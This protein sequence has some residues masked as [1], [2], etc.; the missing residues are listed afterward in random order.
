MKII[1]LVTL[2]IVI[3]IVVLSQES[4]IQKDDF[5][6]LSNTVIIKIKD[7]SLRTFE[8]EQKIN[9]AFKRKVVQEIKPIFNEFTNSLKKGEESLSRIL[10]LKIGSGTDPFL[11]AKKISRLK[12]IEWAEPK[13]I[14]KVT[15]E[16]NDSM[17]LINQQQNLFR[18]LASK[19]WDITKGDSSVIIGIVDTGVDWNHPDISANIYRDNDGNIVGYD[20]GGLNGTPDNDPSEDKAP[21]GVSVGYHGTHVAGI[22]AAVT[23]NKIGIASIGFNCSIMPVKVSRN[24]KRDPQQGEPYVYYGPEGIQYAADH[25]AK[26]INCSWGGYGYSQFEQETINY[27]ISKGALVVAAAG[28]ENKKEPFYPASY[29]GV[30]SVG[31]LDSDD[32]K[33]IYGNSAGSNYGYTLDVFAPGTSI[34]STWPLISGEKYKSISGSSMA[35][36]HVAGLAALVFSRFPNYTPLQVAERIRMTSDDIYSK[37]PDSLYYLLGRGKINAYK[38]VK[39]TNLVS[40]RA[41]NFKFIDK[42]NENGL[43]EKGEQIYVNITFQNYLDPAQNINVELI[44]ND[45]AIQIIN[46]NF[47]ITHLNTLETF[48]NNNNEFTFLINDNAPFNHTVNFM[49]KFTGN[50]Y[51]DFQWFSVRIN[52]TYDTHN[53]NKITMTITS[54]GTLGFN[55]YPDNTEGDGFKFDNGDNL[56]FEGAFMYG[57]SESKVMDAA[58]EN[59]KQSDDFNII[60]QIKISDSNGNQIGTTVF[61]DSNFGVGRLGIETHLTSYSFIEPPNDKYIILLTELK[62]T[63]TQDINGL[64]AGYF[65]DWDMPAEN[66]I[67]DTTA[68]DEVNNFG[69]AFCIDQTAVSTYVGAALISSNNYGFYPIDN[70][71]STGDIQLFDSNGFTKKEK[72][73]SLSSGV[74]KTGAGPSDVSFTISGGPFNIPAGQSIPIAFVVAAGENLNDLRNSI[75][76]SREKYQSLIT[77][78]AE[79]EVLLKEFKLYQNYPNPFNPT[80]V[81]SYQLPERNFVTLKVYDILGREITTL[82]NEYKDAGSYKVEF[83]VDKYNLSSGVYFY[84]LKAGKNFLVKKM[85]LTK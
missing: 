82:V 77:N 80:T 48:T 79:Q 10:E 65:F 54:K 58:R 24:D 4:I 42:P 55:D 33:A 71:A 28:N 72:W 83:S 60:Q 37:N 36:P 64:Y 78:I 31:W 52:P 38:A 62:N 26:V 50:N 12:E 70:S 34:I 73:I 11:V 74:V 23:N 1:Y 49:L 75:Q 56:L 17:Y 22:A 3:P 8:L 35:S 2:L 76:A 15:Y 9:A 63:T 44:C 67:I 20:F 7:G 25:G 69:Y 46:S 14:R 5:I 43:L 51:S 84:I 61:D 19:A 29:N 30:L 45:P 81:I 57:V 27:A 47:T 59:E 41:I 18:I 6:Y 66:P 85:M 40:V 13:F 39:D 16:P 68:Y 53:S 32:K 21:F